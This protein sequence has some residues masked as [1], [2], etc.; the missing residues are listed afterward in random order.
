MLGVSFVACIGALVA[1]WF[2]SGRQWTP[3]LPLPAVM[4]TLLVVL[5]LGEFARN[6]FRLRLRSVLMAMSLF[7]VALGMLGAKWNQGRSQR[8]AIATVRSLESRSLGPVKLLVRGSP[9]WFQPGVSFDYDRGTD[10]GED[11][12]KTTSGMVVPAWL[13]DLS[14]HDYFFKVDR[15]S[16]QCIDM[17]APEV[18]NDVELGFFKRLFFNHCRFSPESIGKIAS[19]RQLRELTFFHCD[20]GDSQLA[21]LAN[22]PQL[23]T[24]SLYKT[25]VTG[26][27]LR[28]LARLATLKHLSVQEMGL[29]PGDLSQLVSLKGLVSLN[30]AGNPLLTLEDME[31]LHEFPMLSG[32][33][34]TNT[35]VDEG[36]LPLLRELPR[37]KWASITPSSPEVREQLILE[38]AS[39][40]QAPTIYIE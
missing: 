29:S 4:L 9:L 3:T 8:R 35:G 5:P 14:G 12:L 17:S 22:L 18:L 28:E 27:G 23:E 30:L 38:E 31:I 36:A 16:L 39:R 13:V 34:L 20:I 1:T 2:L 19:S 10:I 26:D 7:A 32:I 6:R 15:A 24:L 21:T 40:D 25:D 33:N 37:L 11:F